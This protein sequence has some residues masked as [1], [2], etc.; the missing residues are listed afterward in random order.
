[1]KLVHYNKPCL[2]LLKKA[3]H[4]MDDIDGSCLDSRSMALRFTTMTFRGFISVW[5][6]P[7]D[8]R[9]TKKVADR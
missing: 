6:M 8:C 9:S 5:T 1:M 2:V 7:M 3:V 4:I